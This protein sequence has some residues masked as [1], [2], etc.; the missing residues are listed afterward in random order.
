[1]I[2]AAVYRLRARNTAQ[3]PVVHGRLMHA[4]FFDILQRLNGKL[5]AVLHDVQ[6]QKPFTVSELFPCTSLRR[7]SKSF[8]FSEGVEVDWRITA[9]NDPLLRCLQEICP[10]Q[11]LR[12]DHVLLE[13]ERCFLSREEHKE[14][15]ILREKDLVEACLS[16]PGVKEVQFEF[17]S[18]VSFRYFSEDYPWP[19]PEYVF[20]SL[21]DKWKTFHMPLPVGREMVRS[22]AKEVVPRA[23]RGGSR[24]LFLKKDRGILAIEGK[25]CYSTERLPLEAQRIFLLLARFAE[26]SGV[27]RLTGHGLGQTRTEWR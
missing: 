27:G 11:T 3:I 10:G 20:G 19:L 12:V 22:V 16:V 9:L 1:M 25:F 6:S 15:G 5:S 18:P 4:A 2:G 7:V 23:W 8:L 24:T 21:A 14:A 17:R 13:V 26:F